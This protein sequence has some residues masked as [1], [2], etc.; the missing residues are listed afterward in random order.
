MKTITVN[1]EEVLN[2]ASTAISI[3]MADN[4]MRMLIREELCNVTA[5]MTTVLFKDAKESEG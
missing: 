1:E 5:C 4:P 3:C 2:A